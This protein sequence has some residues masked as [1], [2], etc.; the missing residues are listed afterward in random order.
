MS[1]RESSVLT[2]LMYMT[3]RASESCLRTSGG[4]A[5]SGSERFTLDTRSRTSFAAESMLRSRS[6]SMFTKEPPSRL[7]ERMALM[8]SMPLT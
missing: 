8:P 4:R 1:M 7:D 3:G 6:N 2:T 5:S